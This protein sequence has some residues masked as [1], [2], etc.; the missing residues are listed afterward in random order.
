MVIDHRGYP[1]EF[2]CTTPVKPTPIQKIIYGSLLDQYIGVELC[3][4][5]LLAV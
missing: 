2:R 3:G 4:K 1:L 5:R